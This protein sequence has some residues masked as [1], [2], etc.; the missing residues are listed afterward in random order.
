M[1][2]GDLAC[3][4]AADQPQPLPR[5]LC[6]IGG[7][8]EPTVRERE[9]VEELCSELRLAH[10]VCSLGLQP[11]LTSKC[12]K[13]V[14]VMNAGRLFARSLRRV[15]AKAA[16]SEQLSLARRVRPHLHLIVELPAT[17][18]LNEFVVCPAAATLLVDAFVNSHGIYRQTALSLMSRQGEVLTMHA[19]GKCLAEADALQF[20]QERLRGR[21]SERASLQELLLESS[22]HRQLRVLIADDSRPPFVQQ[23]LAS[24][25]QCAEVGAAVLFLAGPAG[26]EERV[27]SACSAAGVQLHGH[28]SLGGVFAGLAYANIL[29][30]AGLLAPSLCLPVPSP[31]QRARRTAPTCPTTSRPSNAHPPAAGRPS[32]AHPPAA[33]QRR[34]APWATARQATARPFS[35]CLDEDMQSI[36][37]AE[38]RIAADSEEPTPE[39]AATSSLAMAKSEESETAEIDEPP[40]VLEETAFRDKVSRENEEVGEQ[41]AENEHA[42][43]AAED[44]A[45]AAKTPAEIAAEASAETAEA[46]EVAETVESVATSA[47]ATADHAETEEVESTPIVAEGARPCERAVHEAGEADQAIP[48][49][50]I[51]QRQASNDAG[52][53]EAATTATASPASTAATTAPVPDECGDRSEA[54][55][56]PAAQA[57]NPQSAA[58]KQESD[59]SSPAKTSWVDIVRRH[60]PVS[61]TAKSQPTSKLS[62]TLRPADA[63]GTSALVGE[64]QFTICVSECTVPQLP[65]ANKHCAKQT[66]LP[67]QT[68]DEAEVASPA[69]STQQEQLAVPEV[70]KDLVLVSTLSPSTPSDSLSTQGPSEGSIPSEGSEPGEQPADALLQLE[71]EHLTSHPSSSS[72][73][74]SPTLDAASTASPT[75]ADVEAASTFADAVAES[76]SDVVVKL[77]DFPSLH[78]ETTSREA[79]AVPS[80]KL[81]WAAI[82]RGVSCK[83]VAQASASATPPG[84][85]PGESAASL[86]PSETVIAAEST[87]A[88]AVSCEVSPE[89]SDEPA[90]LK[91]VCDKSEIQVEDCVAAELAP[92]SESSV[93]VAKPAEHDQELSSQSVKSSSGESQTATGELLLEECG[94][95]VQQPADEMQNPS[96][97]ESLKSSNQEEA[98][99]SSREA[100]D[101]SG[102]SSKPSWADIARRIKL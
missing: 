23:P 86:P 34:P 99:T 54:I 6:V 26:D 52:A 71:S 70:R 8:K 95:E 32:N 13:A 75:P 88:V 61:P 64:C 4:S 33:G 74:K 102:E 37:S 3:G 41:C 100:E 91:D 93:V 18:T 42:A 96:N 5:T 44:A 80:P 55:E 16:P 67:S 83:A 10:C 36:H 50:V 63:T 49:P 56:L 90:T 72:N 21:R 35:E 45:E 77:D 66:S 53:E 9:V 60:V 1:T 29:H 19:P 68:A 98:Q 101:T 48:A 57:S 94:A 92:A 27:L 76:R 24:A 84:E 51:N 79:T 46:A 12:M 85:H 20:L 39:P 62:E 58:A 69:K 89:R 87:E 73:S 11:E 43:E 17:T 15:M 47:A 97:D 81:S 82:A 7:V 59:V 25:A 28:A 40:E 2:L 14:G 65:L 38:G 31:R 30:S 78:K 22:R